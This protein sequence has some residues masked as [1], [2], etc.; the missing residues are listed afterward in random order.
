MGQRAIDSNPISARTQ[1]CRTMAGCIRTLGDANCYRV[2][3][4]TLNGGP[5]PALAEGAHPA[6]LRVLVVSPFPVAPPLHGGRVRTLGIARG[7]ARAGGSVDL[8][9]PWVPGAPHP[10]SPEPRLA[11]HTHRMAANALPVL[12]P[13][14]IAPP[15]ALLSFQPRSRFG[16][17]RWLARFADCD[18]VQFEFCAHSH[19][20]A[21]M[22]RTARIVYSAHNVEFDY[23]RTYPGTRLLRGAGLRRIEHLERAAVRSSD[24]V[25]AC[26]D[27]DVQR[28]GALYGAPRRAA[29]IVNGFDAGLLEFRRAATRD[30]A[31]AALGFAPSD[32]VILFVGGDGAHNREAVRFLT[33]DILPAL[34]GSARLLIAGRSGAAAPAG[35]LRIR[36]PGFVDDL[37]TAFAAADVA[38]NPVAFGSGTNVKLAEYVAVG[39]PVVSTPIGLRGVPHL[40]GV[41]RIAGRERF[42]EALRAPAPEPIVD[43][44]ML[45]A[46]TW[47][48]LGR[49]LLELYRELAQ[50]P[51]D[52]PAA[53]PVPADG[54]DK[55]WP[56]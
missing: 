8:L 1:R 4:S 48:A 29:V 43:R 7:L 17:R 12:V 46:W 36:R 21:L 52:Y 27:D 31:R 44:A 15:L 33:R 9:A 55:R 34:D 42:A 3:Q 25:V 32:R 53:R 18:I 22:P 11:L 14:W 20:A 28:F 38:V 5:T 6:P 39:L 23:H 51:R 45:A 49:R 56:T 35:D 40:E 13:D 30:A 47:D 16:P 41:V 24:L 26:S 10:P 50:V 54:I 2:S 37:R 19:W